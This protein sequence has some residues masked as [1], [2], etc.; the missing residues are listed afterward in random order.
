[1]WTKTKSN[2][3]KWSVNLPHFM[4]VI[5][6]VM[7]KSGDFLHFSSDIISFVNFQVIKTSMVLKC[8]SGNLKPICKKKCSF[9]PFFLV[10]IIFLKI[11]RKVGLRQNFCLTISYEFRIVRRTYLNQIHLNSFRIYKGMNSQEK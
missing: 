1:M 10:F 11:C 5:Y 7:A 3:V 6:V 8:W 9:K 2:L 4:V